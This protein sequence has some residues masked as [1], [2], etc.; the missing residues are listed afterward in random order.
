MATWRDDK[1]LE[2]A[3]QLTYSPAEKRHE[4]LR[5]AVALISDVDA[6]KTYPWDFVHFRITGFQPVSHSDH[7]LSGKI[8]RSDLSTLI[9]FLSDTLAIRAEDAGETVLAIEEVAEKFSVSSKTIQRWRKQGLMALRYI[10]PDGRRRLGFHES[11]VVQF[12]E[13][14]KERV[15]RSAQFK[16]LSDDEKSRIINM[17]RR[18]ALQCRCGMKDLTQRIAHRLHRSPET[19]RYTIR[20]YDHEHPTTAIFP[21]P[22]AT[23]QPVDGETVFTSYQDGVPTDSIATRHAGTPDGIMSVLL[24]E[25]ARRLKGKLIEYM[26]N[27][28]FEHPDAENIILVVLPAEAAAKAVARVAAGTD[29]KAADLFMARM[30]RDLPPNLAEVFHEP[31][32]PQEMET[33]AF[34][35]MNYV[36]FRAAT[37]QQ[38]LLTDE[39]TPED[40]ATIETLLTQA[41]A[42]KN[43]LVRVNLRVAAHVARKHQRPDQGIAELFSDAVIWL[44]RS[45]EKFDFARNVKFSTYAGYAI[46]KNFARDRSEQ[47]TRRDSKMITGQEELLANVGDR[48]QTHV[49]DQ[50]DAAQLK[51]E[52]LSVIQELPTREREL[53]THHYGLDQTQEPLSLSELGEKMGITKARVRQL[54]IRALRKLKSLLET[55][56]ATL[57]KK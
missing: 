7:T 42:I 27:P 9:E 43:D 54:E 25:R 22:S 12:A 24:R 41:S 38:K 45:V 47:L 8:L 57:A 20:K 23:V 55:R 33:D 35:R 15:E 34:R 28:L 48:E 39:V 18:L 4:Q 56:R 50:L 13:S 36:K 52:L 5:A 11:S 16:Q 26:A 21:D 49:A 32:M 30:P 29:A 17:A 3:N 31:L 37:L 19:I 14:N 53:L 1:I 51:N 44:M 2:L 46:M 10:Y 6:T 40:L